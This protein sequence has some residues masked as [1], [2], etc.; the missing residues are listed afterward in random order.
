MI[1]VPTPVFVNISN[2]SEWGMRP[3]TMWTFPTP[4]RMAESADLAARVQQGAAALPDRQRAALS[5]FHGDGLTMAEIATT[6]AVTESAAKSLQVRAYR[7]LRD[8]LQS[9]PDAI[10]REI[11]S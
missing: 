1:S 4:A 6:L 9:D 11:P 2:S 3:S 7:T 5:L 10:S 8:L